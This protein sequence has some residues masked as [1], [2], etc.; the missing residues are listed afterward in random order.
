MKGR[1][2]E[3]KIQVIRLK[4]CETLV[5]RLFDIFGFVVSIPE[6]AG[7]LQCQEIRQQHVSQLQGVTGCQAEFYECD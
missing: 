2:Y 3:V 6:L 1:A 4:V 7:Q 5:Y